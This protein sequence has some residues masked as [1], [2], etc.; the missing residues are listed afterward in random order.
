MKNNYAWTLISFLFL[1]T[2]NLL[3]SVKRLLDLAETT[4]K[5]KMIKVPIRIIPAALM[6][7]SKKKKQ[8]VFL[9]NTLI[10]VQV[11]MSCVTMRTF[12]ISWVGS[13]IRWLVS[14]Y[15][16]CRIRVGELKVLLLWDPRD[17]A[18]AEVCVAHTFNKSTVE[19]CLWLAGCIWASLFSY[20]TSWNRGSVTH[21]I[22]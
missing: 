21:E 9:F 22:I 2:R 7:S 4:I 6:I 13:D 14:I 15:H 18:V 5:H 16:T 8:L 17:V 1:N 12:S 20:I 3:C 10:L 19:A 11:Q